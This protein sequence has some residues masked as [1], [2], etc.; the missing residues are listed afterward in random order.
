MG[1]GIGDL[2]RNGYPDIYTTNIPVGNFLL[3]NQGDGTFIDG[4]TVAGVGAFVTGWAAHFLDHDNDGD[5]D[6]FVANNAPNMLF[7]YSGAFPVPEI[8]TPM[9]LAGSGNTF[10]A[11]IADIDGD[12]DLD[13]LIQNLGE[14]IKLYINHNND[15]ADG[16][17]N[18]FMVKLTG[19]GGNLHAVGARIDIEAGGQ[20]QSRQIFAGIGFK[21]SSSLVQHFGLGSLTTVDRMVV[22]WPTGGQTSMVGLAANQRYALTRADNPAGSVGDDAAGHVLINKEGDGTLTLSWGP[23]CA[24]ADDDYL[25]YAG[26]LHAVGSHEPLACTTSGGTSQVVDP[27]PGDRYYLVVPT[28]GVVEGSYGL[29]GDG[30]ERGQGTSAC[31]PQ[32]IGACAGP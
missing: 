19:T 17:H 6:L 13:L 7:Q 21:S 12:G 1:V 14:K 24:G 3:L 11:A 25:V 15:A 8:A 20:Q 32:S 18:Y 22:T 9:A 30:D 2:D 29:T 16:L 10:C 5:E 23:S 28:N 27:A 26:D 4:T 31:M